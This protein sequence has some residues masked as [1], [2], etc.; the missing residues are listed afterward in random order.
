MKFLF[1]RRKPKHD[2][3]AATPTPLEPAAAGAVTTTTHAPVATVPRVD[4]SE[5]ATR[6]LTISPDVRDAVLHFALDT[7]KASGAKVSIEGEDRFSATLPDG[8]TARYT[9]ALAVAREDD[10]SC[11]LV[12]GGSALSELVALSADKAA[13]GALALAPRAE[14][15]DIARAG[16][17]EP[18]PKCGKCATAG[19]GGII[20]ACEQCPLRDGHIVLLDAGRL[21]GGAIARERDAWSVELAYEVAYSDRQGRRTEWARLA[22]DLASGAPCATLEPGALRLAQAT[23]PAPHPPLSLYEL[24]SL[25]EQALAPQLHAA[26]AFLRLRSGRDFQNRLADLDSTASRLTHESPTD[27]LK[28]AQS[29]AAEVERLREVFAVDVEARLQSVCFVRSPLAEVVFDRRGG[30]L[31]LT[32]DLGRGALLPPPCAGCGRPVHAGRMCPRGHVTCATCAISRDVAV[33][34]P[35]CAADG[36]RDALSPRPRR[37]RR[38]SAAREDGALSVAHLRDMS[39]E[40]WREFVGWLAEQEGV[41]VERSDDRGELILWHGHTTSGDA[42]VVVAALRPL[43][44]LLVSGDDVRNAHAAAGTQQGEHLRLIS[45][46]PASEAASC[47]AQRLGLELIDAEA[48]ARQLSTLEAASASGREAER[49]ATA[50]TADSAAR[51]RATMLSGLGALEETLSRAAN[52]RRASGRA[53]IA[54]AV[55]TAEA[56][57]QDALR[58]F[59]AWDT[60]AGEWMA[61]FD[62]RAG[63]EGA[64]VFLADEHQFAEMDERASHLCAATGPALQRIAS[65]PVSGDLGYSAWRKAI[66]EELTARCEASR[67]RLLGL[68]PARWSD[69]AGA[70]D[71]I[72]LERASGADAAAGHAAARVAKAYNALIARVRP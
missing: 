47:E 67:W 59:L 23:P 50:A 57:R 58:A 21:A 28:I 9:T 3:A 61:S 17:A 56:A 60:L 22:F 13:T 40:T 49:A 19:S 16:L 70:H 46:A 5:I 7:L 2:D 38:T 10:S 35:V 39:R 54:A 64:L 6:P 24:E 12:Q 62:E 15:V 52:S 65:T 55:E 18:L 27:E 11:L 48:L 37:K 69:F 32:V 30:P 8:T 42:P 63:R 45:T 72:A 44:H 25:A 26:A 34:C 43:P 29:H 4:R 31:A 71:T 41:R 66:T 36:T 20:D 1:W 51:A 53:A 33:S 68:D 14:A